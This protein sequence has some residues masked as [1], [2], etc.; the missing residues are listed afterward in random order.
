[1][2]HSLRV[3]TFKISIKYERIPEKQNKPNH[4]PVFNNRF[5]FKTTNTQAHHIQNKNKKITKK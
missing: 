2:R 4:R 1:M 3:Y 5:P